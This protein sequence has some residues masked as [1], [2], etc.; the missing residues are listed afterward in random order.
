MPSSACAL[1]NF[2]RVSA[3]SLKEALVLD[4]TALHAAQTTIIS[5]FGNGTVCIAFTS[6][7]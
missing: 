1:Q 5:E 6:A 7:T 2:G 4:P 3:G